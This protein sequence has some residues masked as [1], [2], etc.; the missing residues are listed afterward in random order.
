[1]TSVGVFA[2]LL[3]L[4]LLHTAVVVA[5]MAVSVGLLALVSACIHSSGVGVGVDVY[6]PIEKLSYLLSLLSFH[7]HPSFSHT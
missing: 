1:M 7:F 6:F 2:L 4:C 3:V 5:A